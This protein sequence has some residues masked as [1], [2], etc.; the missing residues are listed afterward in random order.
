MTRRT[1]LKC[2]MAPPYDEM[3]PLMLDFVNKWNLWSQTLNAGL[4]DIRLERAMLKAWRKLDPHL[5]SIDPSD[6]HK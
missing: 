6:H 5:I 2:L 4:R 3:G 1:L